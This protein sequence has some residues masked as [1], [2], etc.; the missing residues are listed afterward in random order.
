MDPRGSALGTSY[1]AAYASVHALAC[2]VLLI[3]SA[4]TCAAASDFL[5]IACIAETR[6]FSVEYKRADIDDDR[7]GMSDA[8]VKAES[9]AW[10][11][12]GY[13]D[14]TALNYECLLPES[15]Y[16]LSAIHSQSRSGEVCDVAITLMW[17]DEVG[18]DGVRIG[19]RCADDVTLDSFEIW[20]GRRTV[21][22]PRS[23]MLCMGASSGSPGGRHCEDFR[24]HPTQR[25]TQVLTQRDLEEYVAARAAVARPDEP[26]T[27]R[28]KRDTRSLNQFLF[29]RYPCEFPGLQLP[30]DAVVHVLINGQTRELSFGIDPG[31][32]RAYVGDVYVNAPG[33]RVALVL[34]GNSG[35]TVWNFHWTPSTEIVAVA[36]MAS[37]RLEFAGL[38]SGTPVFSGAFGSGTACKFFSASPGFPESERR[39]VAA[40]VEQ[41]YRRPADAMTHFQYRAPAALGEKASAADYVQQRD[42]TVESFATA[43]SA[44]IG[45]KGLEK[46]ELTGAIRKAT[47]QDAATWLA[48]WK[49]AHPATAARYTVSDEELLRSIGL[50]MAFIIQKPFRYPPGLVGAD[51]AIFFVPKGAS[52]PTGEQ[53]HSIIYDFNSGSCFAATQSWCQ[54]F[55]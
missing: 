1:R 2:A 25:H 50:W 4:A 43:S 16:R 6:Y 21:R 11:R 27:G 17:N 30:N 14:P 20:D 3:P 7:D 29:V 32:S 53:G 23:M 31:V 28:W 47:Q 10:I 41:V 33:K 19:P 38:P 51:R 22:R 15:T 42:V 54:P 26:P 9:R 35:P 37:S 34:V 40:F 49:A 13:Y 12:H 8:E 24:P 55:N 52:R 48:A 39:E 18:L 45:T 46:L 5:R 44:L 36:A